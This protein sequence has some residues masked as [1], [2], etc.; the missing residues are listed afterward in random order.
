MF[1]L[2]VTYLQMACMFN[3]KQLDS[4]CLNREA[5]QYHLVSR[6]IEMSETDYSKLSPAQ[7]QEARINKALDECK[8][9]NNLPYFLKAILRCMLKWEA[10]ERPNF[11]KLM[12]MFEDPNNKLMENLDNQDFVDDL[13]ESI[14]SSAE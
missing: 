4:Y 2:G 12:K 6:Y 3:D 5:R 10:Q 7:Q 1:S 8:E 11:I 9:H 14:M 13:I